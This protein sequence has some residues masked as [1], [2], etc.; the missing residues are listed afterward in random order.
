MKGKALIASF[1]ILFT[2]ACT[3]AIDASYQP[4]IDIDGNRLAG[5]TIAVHRFEDG[6]PLIAPDHDK[7]ES[8]VTRQGAWKIGLKYDDQ[9]LPP[10]AIVLQDV[11]IDEFQAVGMQAV[12]AGEAGGS[13]YTLDGRIM[14]FGFSNDA[15]IVT[16][17]SSRRVSLELTL[18]DAN[19]EPLFSERVFQSADLENEGM[20]VAHT[21]NVDKL[22]SGRLKE[23]VTEVVTRANRELADRGVELNDVKLNGYRIGNRFAAFGADTPGIH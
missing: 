16:V 18:A 22:M 1:S 11:F 5:K 13:A 3:N 15:G 9:E 12:K 20:A 17:E 14:E 23:V 2:T 4:G 7:A 10:I 19:G 21:T 6:R 8:F